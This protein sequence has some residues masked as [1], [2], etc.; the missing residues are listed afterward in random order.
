MFEVPMTNFSDYTVS[1][2]NTKKQI[3]GNLKGVRNEN[4]LNPLTTSVPHHIETSQMICRMVSMWWGT[5]V[6]N[7]LKKKKT[8]DIKE[9]SS[10][11]LQIL[12]K[13]DAIVICWCVIVKF[14]IEWT[15]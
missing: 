10:D 11:S 6:V 7:G 1:S 12:H 2:Y 15:L 4:Q 3:S 8:P 14:K 13:V 5:L 9:L